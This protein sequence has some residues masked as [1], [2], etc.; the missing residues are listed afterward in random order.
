MQVFQSAA[1]SALLL[2]VGSVNAFSL[3]QNVARPLSK[4]SVA[5]DVTEQ[6]QKVPY[7]I[8]RGDGSTGG[9]GLPMPNKDDGLV[10]PKVS[11]YGLVASSVLRIN[12]SL[13]RFSLHV[14]GC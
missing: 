4:L 7:E 6:Q 11:S 8:A 10:R 1:L 3:Q 12:V 2:S 9:G 5:N 13:T 14:G